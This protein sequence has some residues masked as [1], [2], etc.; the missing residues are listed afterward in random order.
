MNTL[1][2]ILKWIGVASDPV[3]Q[4]PDLVQYV[5]IGGYIVPLVP[6][7]NEDRTRI[8]RWDPDPGVVSAV[9]ALGSQRSGAATL[10]PPLP[11]APG[12]PTV[13]APQF[14]PATACGL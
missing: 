5:E 1:M 14:N 13:E 3:P 2:R 11:T 7:W 12:A 6:V 10:P 4:D 9:Q 8:A